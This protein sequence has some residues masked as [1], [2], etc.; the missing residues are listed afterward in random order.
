MGIKENLLH[1]N[2]TKQKNICFPQLNFRFISHSRNPTAGRLKILKLQNTWC[3]LVLSLGEKPS[4]HRE[5]CVCFL[6]N[7]QQKT[8]EIVVGVITRAAEEKRE[9]ILY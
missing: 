7:K 4:P 8:E 3:L 5:R 2:T 6:K 1:V 9:K